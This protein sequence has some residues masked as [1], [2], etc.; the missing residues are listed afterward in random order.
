MEKIECIDKNGNKRMLKIID[1]KDFKQKSET[2]HV[3]YQDMKDKKIT[4]DQF[5]IIYDKG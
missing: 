4:S 2:V 1:Y 5:E 3:A